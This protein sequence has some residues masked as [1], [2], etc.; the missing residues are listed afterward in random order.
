MVRRRDDERHLSDRRIGLGLSAIVR[1]EFYVLKTTRCN[2]EIGPFEG[3]MNE[4][5]KTTTHSP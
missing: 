5:S 2:E 4:I 1:K 3:P